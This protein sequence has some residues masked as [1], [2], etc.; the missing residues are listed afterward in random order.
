M[1]PE[2]GNVL[3]GAAVFCAVMTPVAAL[4]YRR[5]GPA[6]FVMA[7]AFAV[8]AVLCWLMREDPAT[9]ARLPLGGLLLLLLLADAA[10]RARGLPGDRTPEKVDPQENAR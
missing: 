2:F 4:Q 5:R 9:S 1:T 8:L 10:L 6:A 3:L 7:A